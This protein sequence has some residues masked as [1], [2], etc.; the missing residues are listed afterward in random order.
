MDL[1][2]SIIVPVF[3]EEENVAP[4]EEELAAVIETLP[5]AS[6]VVFVDDGSSDRSSERLAEVVARR[7]WARLVRLKRN[8]GQ[9]QAMAAGFHHARGAVLVCM[10]ADL[11]NDPR[12]IPRLLEVMDRG[13]DIVSG[14]RRDRKD[15]MLTRRLPSICANWLIGRLVG[16]KI[17]DYGCSL[18]AYDARVMRSLHLYSDMHR[19]LPALAS[20]CGARV[21]EIPVNHRPRRHGVSKYGLSRI[22]KVVID[23]T[24]IKMI[25]DFSGRPAHAFGSIGTVYLLMALFTVPFLAINLTVGYRN[26][27]VIPSV[28]VLT[29]VGALYFYAI[30]VLADLIVRVGEHDASEY[31]RSTA[32]ELG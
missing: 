9:T 6:E 24:V 13:Y 27:M 5:G 23:L 8:F 18:K 31:A 25:V 3:N 12:D 32:V 7:P 10:D 17:H 4:L 14:W 11:Q 29:A 2:L 26:N 21:T 19:F 1:D 30:G 15:K 22:L 28:L 16:V 20:K